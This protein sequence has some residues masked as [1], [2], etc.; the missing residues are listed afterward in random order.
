MALMVRP[1]TL[2]LRR[3]DQEVKPSEHPGKVAGFALHEG[4]IVVMETAGGGGY[5]D[6]LER[7]TGKSAQR[8]IVRISER[9]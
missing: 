1:I 4:D 6:P 5:G 8:Y 2:P 3:N 7:D 9:R